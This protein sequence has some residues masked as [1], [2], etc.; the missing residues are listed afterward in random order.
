MDQLLQ[1]HLHRAKNC[2]KKQADLHRSERSFKVGDLVFLKLQPYVQTSLAPRAHQKLAFRFFGLYRVLARIDFVA[3]KREFPVHSSI[4]PIF[5]VSQLSKL[6]D[7][8]VRLFLLY[9]LI[10]RSS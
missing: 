5:H 1:H 4:H 2:M 7:R 9:H 3:Y 8:S 10:L 6:L